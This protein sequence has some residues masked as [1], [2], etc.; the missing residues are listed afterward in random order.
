MDVLRTFVLGFQLGSFSRAAERLGRS[1]SAISTQLRKLEDQIGQPLVRKAGRGLALTDVGDTLFSYA[2]R[3]LALNDEAIAAT[4]GSGVEGWVKLGLSQDFAESWLA[5][6]LAQFARL[7]PKVRVEAQAEKTG[8]LLEKTIR[9]ELDMTLGWGSTV[10]GL[11]VEHLADIP[12][13]WVGPRDWPGM[14]ALPGDALS[15]VAFEPPCSFRDPAIAALDKAGISWRVVFSSP[16]LSGLWAAATAGLGIT[17]RT[18]IGLPDSLVALD[19]KKLGLPKLPS[20]PLSLYS[21]GQAGSTAA[22]VLAEIL[23]DVV[24]D[25]VAAG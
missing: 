18:S 2:Q 11:E 4:R 10:E 17:M 12:M 1:P 8:A 13:V 6:V 15:L 7:H 9:G 16:S 19:A 3:I 24:R 25:K 5:D 20:V 21:V 23:V 14:S 22:T